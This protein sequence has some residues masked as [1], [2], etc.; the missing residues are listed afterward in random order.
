MGISLPASIYEPLSILQR[1][2]EMLEYSM[3]LDKALEVKDPIDRLVL[4][5]GFAVSGYSGTKRMHTNFNPI[6]GETFEYTDKR[7]GTRFL[8]EQ[9]SHHPPISA[10]HGFNTDWTFYQN[11][12]AVTKFLGNAI[13]INTQG[14]THIVFNDLNDN[15]YYTNPLTRAHNIIL[16][17]MCVEHYGELHITNIRTQDTCKL[18]FKKCNFFQSVDSKIEGWVKN[19][20][21]DIIVNLEG[22]WD[23]YLNAT[24]LADTSESKAEKT[25]NIW[26][27]PENNFT[28]DKYKMTKFA[29]TLND[30]DDERLLPPTDSRF[31]LDRRCLQQGENSRATKLKKIMEERQRSDKK[32]REEEM[33]EWEPVWFKLVD[34]DDRGQLWQYQGNYWEQKDL[35][36]QELENGNNADEL[37]NGG[38]A[39]NTAADFKSYPTLDE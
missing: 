19:A 1:Q 10:T 9:V 36:L 8:G 14:R 17:K 39:S 33:R 6:L 20:D 18:F 29:A 3:L 2:S 26:S 13:D 28:N 35:K 38:N 15:F 32:L 4:V 11:S 23:E 16:G 25:E 34:D 30:I 37:L 21:G 7:N 31:R 5:A 24:W 12:S 22:K 27:L